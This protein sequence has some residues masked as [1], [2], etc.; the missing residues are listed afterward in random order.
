MKFTVEDYRLIYAAVCEYRQY[1]GLKDKEVF[2]R[3]T[4][5]MDAIRPFAYSQKVEQHT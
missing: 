3:A 1:C 2:D 4:L 5:I